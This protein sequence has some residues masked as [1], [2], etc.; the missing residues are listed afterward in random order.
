[1]AL[2]RFSDSN[3][4][5]Y[6]PISD[7]NE[8]VVFG[9]GHCTETQ[10]R[11]DFD[12]TVSKLIGDIDDKLAVKEFRMYLRF[13]LE[14]LRD[15]GC[16]KKIRQLNR[17]GTIYKY[18]KYGHI[19]YVWKYPY[20]KGANDIGWCRPKNQVIF[21]KGRKYADHEPIERSEND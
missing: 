3:W 8:L 15:S 12:G 2:C 7:E 4:Y 20:T 21:V 10:L 1:M 17:I 5:I 9:F 11:T 18:T 14:A 16:W 19:P 6:E 13:W